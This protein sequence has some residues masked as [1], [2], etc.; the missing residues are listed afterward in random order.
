MTMADTTAEQTK[1][2]EG[3]EEEAGIDCNVEIEDAGP[4]RKKLKIEIPAET[5]SEHVG[6]SVDTF[7]VEAAVPGFRKGR[8]PR[9][10]VEKR[11]GTAIRRETKNQL[12]AQAYSK[13]VE[14]NGLK[15]LGEPITEGLEDLEI[16]EGKP[17]SFEV[18]V[19]V[20]PEFELP[21]LDGIE[22]D[23]PTLEVADEMVKK[24]IDR[25]CMAEGE[26]EPSDKPKKGDYLTGHA[27]MTDP[28]GKAIYDI[29]DA[30]IQ[31]PTPE[32]EGKGMILGLLVEDFEKQLGKPKIGDTI[33]IKTKGPESHESEDIRGK[34]LMITFRVDRA[35]RIIP[36]T[37]ESLVERFGM[38]N[39]EQLADAVRGRLEQRIAVE[40]QSVMRQQIAAHL[41]NAVEIELPERVT[42]HQASRNL[43]RQRL[44]LMHRGMDAA[45]IEQRMAELRAGSAQMAVRE[46]KL[47]FILNRAAEQLNISVSEEEINGRI[48]Q[49][50]ASRG[51]RPEKLRQEL[52]QR[53][54]VGAVY[55]Q[56]REHKTFD[57]IISKAK[58]TEMS[59]EEFN[60]KMRA[61]RDGTGE[62][63]SLETGQAS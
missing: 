45:Q 42:A 11:F 46:L 63:I 6:S 26:L 31:I 52:M 17:L 49:L 5:V 3:Q 28:D 55:Q 57:A 23:K 13:A 47:F 1:P 2:T 27:T 62:E 53:N 18:Q 21:S 36:A 38:E 61:R 14:D 44:E 30:V 12:V 58:V 9:R 29:A 24:E 41:I 7:L 43:S 56:V 16:E 59:A 4:S 25:I 60:K 48:A 32:R 22:V 20:L 54:Q 39:E 40:Q 15:V 50:A 33:T 8:A 37:K 51:E 19:E 34:D 35:D 10:L